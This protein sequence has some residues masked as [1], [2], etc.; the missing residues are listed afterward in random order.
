MDEATAR[1][2]LRDGR[3]N[4][5][6]WTI[7]DA[8]DEQTVL[9]AGPWFLGSNGYASH[10]V[11]SA[12]TVRVIRLHRLLL[13]LEPGD[14]MEGDHVNRDRLDNRRANLR[15]VTVTMN[16]Q[17]RPGQH[18]S[19]AH[20]GVHWNRKDQRWIAKA[21]IGGVRHHLGSFTTEDEAA[22]AA[23]SFRLAHMP[24]AVD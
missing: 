24:G 6:A 21:T 10:S 17:N 4:I 5:R 11:R 12:G 9:A 23:R 3:G 2:P 16:R 1:I 15:A 14:Q 7:V 18:G 13:G 19:S 8:A 20:R 22:T